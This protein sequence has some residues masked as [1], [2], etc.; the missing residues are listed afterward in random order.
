MSTGTNK[1]WKLASPQGEQ[2][3]EVQYFFEIAIQNAKVPVALVSKYSAPDQTLLEKSSGALVLCD[4]LGQGA[5]EVIP[6]KFIQATVAMV[7][8]PHTPQRNRFFLVERM[9]L[10]IAFLGGYTEEI[11]EEGDTPQDAHSG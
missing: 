11:P 1:H 7:P 6:I 9:G 4:Y 10:D 5:L 8:Y 3:A 2:I